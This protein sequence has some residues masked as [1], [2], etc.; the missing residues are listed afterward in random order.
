MGNNYIGI[1]AIIFGGCFFYI[2]EIFPNWQKSSALKKK[3]I[4][5]FQNNTNKKSLDSMLTYIK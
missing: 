1:N 2:G 5:K 3:K 4:T